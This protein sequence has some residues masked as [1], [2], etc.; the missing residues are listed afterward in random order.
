MINSEEVLA[1][2]RAMLQRYG[3]VSYRILTRLPAP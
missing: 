1:Q 3:R 2:T